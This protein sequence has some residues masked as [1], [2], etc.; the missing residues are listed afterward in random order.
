MK[1]KRMLVLC[2][3][4]EG[5]AAGQRLKYEQ[6][7]NQWRAKGWEIDISSFMDRKMWSVV[8]KNGHTNAKIFGTL[9]GHLRRIGD[10]F[11][12]PRYDIIYV[13]MYVTPLL[14]SL[15]ERLVRLLAKRIIYDIE[16]N[17]HVQQ[18]SFSNNN[19]NPL[20]KFLKW[21][22][23][24]KF[25]IQSANHVITSSPFLNIDCKRITTFGFCSYITSSVDTDRYVPKLDFSDDKIVTIGWTGTYSSK[26]YLDQ[27]RDVFKRLSKRVKFKLKVIGNFNYDF[28]GIDLE[29][30]EWNLENEIRDLQT[31]DIGIYPLPLDSWVHGKSGLKAIQY[32]ALGLPCVATDIGTTPMIIKDK[33]NGILVKSD[34]EWIKAL[35]DLVRYPESRRLIGE[36]ARRE[37]INKYSLNT[38]GNTYD[39]VLK[40]VMERVK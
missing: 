19:P 24:V 20:I 5:V 38:I 32:M 39:N 27:L 4:P 30:I 36:Q 8:Y 21:P 22:G 34:D 17:I 7:F 13:F 11:R 3:F 1:R 14:T 6:Y 23:K 33:V 35:E 37:V 26:I 18:E 16:D 40:E 31:F 28:P 29:V 2:P 9:R 10:L 25:L 15:M 12:V